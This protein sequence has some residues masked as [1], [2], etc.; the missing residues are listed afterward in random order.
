MDLV[1]ALKNSNWVG[2]VWNRCPVSKGQIISKVSYGLLNSSKK[3]TK[4][5]ILR[6]E[7]FRLVFG[8]IED[9]KNC[10]RDLLTFTI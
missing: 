3:R 7:E 5:T 8:R 4:L 9:A 6:K 2:L 10:F 1:Y